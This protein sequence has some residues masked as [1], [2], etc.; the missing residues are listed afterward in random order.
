M[1]RTRARKYSRRSAT[2]CARAKALR[3]QSARRMR[4]LECER[5]ESARLV[6]LYKSQTVLKRRAKEKVRLLSADLAR[7]KE[8]HATDADHIDDLRSSCEG[9]IDQIE[10]RE[11]SLCEKDEVIRRLRLKIKEF[12]AVLPQDWP[13]NPRLPLGSNIPCLPPAATDVATATAAKEI[14]DFT[15]QPPPILRALVRNNVPV[16]DGPLFPEFP[17][18]PNVLLSPSGRTF[19][20]GTPAPIGVNRLHRSPRK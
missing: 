13:S 18:P 19:L 4:H 12:E 1:V 11:E 16:S 8:R 15:L 7:A 6:A 9:Y 2:R 5:E 3:E 17:L 10:D 14:G 20:S